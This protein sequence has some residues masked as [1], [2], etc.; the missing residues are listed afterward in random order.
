MADKD[1]IWE[2]GEMSLESAYNPAI[3]RTEGFHLVLLQR[4]KV[5]SPWVDPELY[6]RMSVVAAKACKI[7]EE[8]GMAD[9]FNIPLRW[10]YRCRKR[11]SGY[12]H[13]YSW[14]IEDRA[15]MGRAASTTSWRRALW[16]RD[17]YRSRDRIFKVGCRW[18]FVVIK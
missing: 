5:P 7:M 12:A 6:G 8:I 16:E 10:K 2:N 15:T 1:V 13:S 18:P 3:P 14:T 9:W 4:K 17:A 11:H